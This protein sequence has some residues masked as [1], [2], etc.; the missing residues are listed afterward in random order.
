[1]P[2]TERALAT[3]QRGK[4]YH[5]LQLAVGLGKCRKLPEVLVLVSGELGSEL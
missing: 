5:Y 2:G 3:H 1:M 4:C